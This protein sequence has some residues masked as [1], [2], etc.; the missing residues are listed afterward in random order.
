LQGVGVAVAVLV[1]WVVK[2]ECLGDELIIPWVAVHLI[3]N[4]DEL[5]ATG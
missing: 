1:E 2:S 5:G 4:P 3:G